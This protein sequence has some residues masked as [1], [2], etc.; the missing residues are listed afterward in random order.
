[1]NE[2]K[3]M[4]MAEPSLLEEATGTFEGLLSTYS[5]DLQRDAVV[6]GA[7]IATIAELKA[8]R[9]ARNRR[10]LIPILWQHQQDK[11]VGG[12]LDMYETDR[13]LHIKGELMMETEL[14]RT[15]WAALKRQVVGGLS[16]G[17]KVLKDSIGKDG[18]RLLLQVRLIEASIVTFPAQPDAVVSPDD[19]KGGEPTN[20]ETMRAMQA[21]IDA[22]KGNSKEHQRRSTRIMVTGKIRYGATYSAKTAAT[23]LGISE[24]TV[25]RWMQEG[26]AN[27]S[28]PME[29]RGGY[30]LVKGEY[31][32]NLAAI[33]V[34]ELKAEWA[35]QGRPS[36]TVVAYEPAR[37]YRAQNAALLE[38][39][40]EGDKRDLR[41]D[42]EATER[43]YEA[44]NEALARYQAKLDRMPS[45]RK[46]ADTR[47]AMDD[48]DE[49]YERPL[50]GR[51]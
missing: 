25:A 6:P 17:Y 11:P 9:K 8:L 36:E 16:M 31:L 27:G 24:A 23:E 19:V 18:V 1:M 37:D 22:H 35:M 15:A 42:R 43:D 38:S 30:L 29:R 47:F 45:E 10:Y 49:G 21:Y 48:G 33:H 34:N 12:V 28:L 7:F 39:L 51:A 13:G 44:S 41:T 14:G 46:A 26:H 4:R 40:P 5:V 2:N 3:Q 32:V 20:L 50:M